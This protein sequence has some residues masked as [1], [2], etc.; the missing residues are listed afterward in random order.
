M[1]HRPVI[2][3][4]LMTLFIIG[5]NQTTAFACPANQV[6][7]VK[8]TASE[9]NREENQTLRTLFVQPGK[10]FDL[11]GDLG[12]CKVGDVKSSIQINRGEK[13]VS[14]KECLLDKVSRTYLTCSAPGSTG[15]NY[16]IDAQFN[17]C[18]TSS[19][20]RVFENSMSI[21]SPANLDPRHGIVL[22]LSC[23][24]RDSNEKFHNKW[25]Q[26]Y[27]KKETT[28]KNESSNSSP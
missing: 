20:G 2:F 8:G 4:L 28:Q 6:W 25:E 21:S 18:T 14:N 26:V 5:W 3:Q 19:S 11:P 16:T 22:S 12:N 15:A 24:S 10:E 23:Y 9:L 1:Y 27:P 17:Q 7:A 13:L